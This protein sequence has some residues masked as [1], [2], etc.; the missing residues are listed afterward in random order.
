VLIAGGFGGL[1]RKPGV[2]PSWLGPGRA[3]KVN[4]KIVSPIR[5]IAKQRTKVDL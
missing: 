5:P 3:C 2:A 4:E 1:G